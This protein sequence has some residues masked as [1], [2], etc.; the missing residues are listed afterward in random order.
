LKKNR[1]GLD[2]AL[3]QLKNYEATFIVWKLDRLGRS[4][5]CVITMIEDFEK[6]GNVPSR[7]RKMTNS[8]M[9][10][11]IKYL[12]EC[13]PVKETAEAYMLSVPTLYRLNQASAVENTDK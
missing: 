8:K 2:K 1:H 12:Q 7:K 4:V 6:R 10:M 11:A 13:I 9:D 3:R 5:K